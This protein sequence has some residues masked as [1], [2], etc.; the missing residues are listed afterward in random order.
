MTLPRM[1][2]PRP[3]YLLLLFALL[4]A[5]LLAAGCAP[6]EGEAD[7]ADETAAASAEAATWPDS[8]LCLRGDRAAAP[9]TLTEAEREAGWILLFDG[10]DLARWRGYGQDDVPASWQAVDGT[11][12]FTP[13]AG[14]GG[15][16]ITRDRY[17][18]FALRLA[19]KISEGGN[20]GIFYN[21]TEQYDSIW[22]SAPEMQVLDNEGH[23]DSQDPTHRAGAPYDLSAPA[24]DAT[25][26]PG[27][28]NRT[29]IVFHDGRGAHWMNGQ[30]L[31]EYDMGS[32]EW[33]Q[34]IAESKVAEYAYAEAEEGRIGLQDHGNRVWYRN[35]MI[36]PLD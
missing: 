18:D 29:C 21:A 20:S 22:K 3:V 31:L 6:S 34:I 17:G 25:R 26:E 35:I 12:G 5:L 10:E 27:Q 28:W 30:K 11:L 33:E 15:N 4:P 9:N 36:L 24:T 7:E 13:G 19:W 14:E 1:D 8:S 16:I 2:F 32:E 23:P